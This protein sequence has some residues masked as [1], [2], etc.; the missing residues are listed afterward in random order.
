MPDFESVGTIHGVT[1]SGGTYTFGAEQLP[2]NWFSRPTPFDGVEF[3]TD[4]IR[5]LAEYPV[6]LGGNTASGSF[7]LLSAGGVQDGVIATPDPET[8]LCL[9]YQALSEG[10]LYGL[11]LSVESLGFILGKV[12]PVFENYGCPL[13]TL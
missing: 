2:P 6:L 11:E 10:T 13:V 3:A 5:S 1:K 12:N 7:D 9:F 4:F 8:V